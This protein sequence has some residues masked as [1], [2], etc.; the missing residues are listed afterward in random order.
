MS[1]LSVKERW[2]AAL[3]LQPLDRLPFWP[4][5]DRAYP[6]AQRPPFRD[7]T[8][9]ALHAWIGSDPHVWMASALIEKRRECRWKTIRESPCS[10]RTLF[11]TPAGTLVAVSHFDERSQ[12]WHPVTY[13]VRTADDI[14]R[15]I[16]FTRDLVIEPDPNALEAAQRQQAALGPHA[17]TAVAVGTSPLMDW[18]QHLA[19]VE[20]GH[21]LL[22]DR[23]DL[24]ETLFDA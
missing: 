8:I 2:L 1:T 15:M 14:H 12:S 11:N 24:V 23:P 6:Q 7:M 20:N 3:R 17:V 16:L 5:L 9:P 22:A 19:G 18:L 10:A 4:K 13:P 21:Y